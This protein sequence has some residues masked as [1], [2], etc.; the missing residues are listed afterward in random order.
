MAQKT[1]AIAVQRYYFPIVHKGHLQADDVGEQFR[2][3]ELTGDYGA[4]IAQDIG[5]DP[6]YDPASGTIVIVVD[7][8]GSEIRRHVVVGV[9]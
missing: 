1:E 6:E 4:R 5:S 9:Y 8:D 2:S 7:A 3:A